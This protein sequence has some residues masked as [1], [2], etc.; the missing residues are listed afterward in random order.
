ML[1]AL[2]ESEKRLV[3]DVRQ[4]IP[5]NGHPGRAWS[6]VEAL[7]RAGHDENTIRG[8]VGDWL[9]LWQVKRRQF[10]TLTP[11]SAEHLGVEIDEDQDDDPFWSRRGHW[12]RPVR[13]RSFAS[14]EVPL[15]RVIKERVR[16]RDVVDDLIELEAPQ[17]EYLVDAYTGDPVV[18]LG[19]KVKIDQRLR[20]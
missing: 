15:T 20:A 5:R 13:S 3:D 2:S 10:V 6:A 12:A 16:H 18:I 19:V 1:K 4:G 17:P 14:R 7:T 8:I 9:A 11:L